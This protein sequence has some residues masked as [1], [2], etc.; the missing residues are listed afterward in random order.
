MST[1]FNGRIVVVNESR[2]VTFDENKTKYKSFGE[3]DCYQ[4]KEIDENLMEDYLSN[5]A[6][7]EK[8]NPIISGL[9]NIKLDSDNEDTKRI[10][11]H[12]LNNAYILSTND[13]RRLIEHYEKEKQ[14]VEERIERLDETMCNQQSLASYQE[15]EC[16]LN[17]L[18]EDL[19][20]IDTKLWSLK[21]FKGMLEVIENCYEEENFRGPCDI[22]NAYLIIV[23]M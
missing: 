11:E 19:S 18:G 13:I 12:L 6:D 9:Y 14:K 17:T 4:F 23:R 16:E 10:H 1:C 3:Y 21:N 8:W 5:Y 22:L 2:I 20:E 15:M 7:R